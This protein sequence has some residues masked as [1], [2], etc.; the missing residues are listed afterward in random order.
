MTTVEASGA[1]P[2]HCFWQLIDAARAG[3]ASSERP[4]ADVL[5]DL[6]AARSRR[7]IVAYERTFGQ[8]RSTLYRWDVWAAAYVIGGGC[9]DDAFM[10]FGAG[11]IALGRTGYDEVLASPDSLAQHPVARDGDPGRLEDL[12]F[13]EEANYAAARA[14]P[15]ATGDGAW[16]EVA[17]ADDTDA[18]DDGDTDVDHEGLDP[19][20]AFD[21]DDTQ[22]MRRR[23]PALAALFLP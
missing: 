11:V 3:S 5:S 16:E 21:F 15:R 9:S 8:V 13:D 12:L 4:F 22:E 2:L 14:F 20:E 7:E 18:V 10:D 19:A 6:L 17:G 23:L 1:M